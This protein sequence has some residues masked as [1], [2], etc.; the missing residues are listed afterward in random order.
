VGTL[1]ESEL[2]NHHAD[3]TSVVNSSNV[4]QMRLVWKIDTEEEVSHMPLVH[5][6]NVFFADWGGS[7]YKVDARSGKVVWKKKV[8]EKVMEKWPWYGF[9]GTGAVV[10]PLNLLVEASVEGMAYGIDMI[11]GQVKWSTRIADDP[12]AGSL[13]KITYYDG[14]VYL[15]LQSVEEP[16]SK[17][18]PDMPVNFQGKVLALDARTGRKVWER[19]LVTPP[20][21]GVPVW[22]SFAID[23]ELN[24]LYT[25][26][27]NNYTGEATELS[28]AL[29]AMDPKTGA[30]KWARQV[31]QHD[32]WTMA[33]PKGPDYDFGAGPQ[34]FEAGGRKLV[35]AGQKSGV[36]YVWDRVTGEPVWTHT[37]GYGNVGG[38]IHGEGSIGTDRVL[39]WGNNAFPYKDPEQHPMD[40]KAVDK[41]TGKLLWAKPKAQPALQTSAGFLANDVYFIGSL[42]GKVRAYNALNGD[43]L[44]TSQKHGP[45][46]SSINVVGGLMMWGAGVPERFG[47]GK[48]YGVFAYSALPAAAAGGQ[49]SA[50]SEQRVGMP[51]R[52]QEP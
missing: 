2:K 17:M 47:G 29:L 27:G 19:P 3:L 44:W 9:A 32:T 22:S 18:T 36:F 49:A 43:S 24:T 28:D 5:R 11:T 41:A 7:V 35:G 16:L 30:I 10:E 21:N 34:L 12:Q 8:A 1:I 50:M 26:T 37:V 13:A 46:A 4:K 48:P 42:D 39:I 15:G 40:I 23:P 31:T 51:V 20:H 6:G 45:V 52:K 25:T 14:L 38:G 33:D